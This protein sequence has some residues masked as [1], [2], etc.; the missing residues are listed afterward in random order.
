MHVGRCISPRKY[1]VFAFF[2]P[3]PGLTTS[4]P[5]FKVLSSVLSF[6]YPNNRSYLLTS[7]ASG[8]PT[9]PTNTARYQRKTRQTSRALNQMREMTKMFGPCSRFPRWPFRVSDS[10][11]KSTFGA[12]GSATVADSIAGA[13]HFPPGRE[14]RTGHLAHRK[15][16][17]VTEATSNWRWPRKLVS[18]CFCVMRLCGCV[19]YTFKFGMGGVLVRH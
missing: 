9:G 6:M 5:N 18:C 17:K 1:G 4:A 7:L 11:G 12:S 8:R 19:C 14:V 2:I 16:D 10:R 3:L 15:I 13:S